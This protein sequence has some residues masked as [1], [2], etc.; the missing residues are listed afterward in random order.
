MFTMHR[1]QWCITDMLRLITM[2]RESITAIAS[3]VITIMARDIIGA[4]TSIINTAIAVAS[5]VIID[6]LIQFGS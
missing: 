2:V 5:A 6:S 3:R 1:Q 4:G